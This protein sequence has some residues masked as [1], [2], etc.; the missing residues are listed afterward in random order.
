VL[1]GDRSETL[2]AGMAAVLVGVPIIH[3]HGG[4]ESQGATDNLWR[5]ALTKLSHLHLVSHPEHAARVL[6]MGEDPATVFVVGA[7]GLDNLYRKDLPSRKSIAREIGHGLA[8]PLVIVTVHPAMAGSDPLAEVA[9]VATALE[10]VEATYLITQPNADEGGKA[11]R[12][13]WMDWARGR[14]NVALVDALGDARYWALLREASAVLGNSSS[15][16]IEAPSIGVPVVNVGDRQKGRMRYGD[17]A[18]VP[19][20]ADRIAAALRD[21]LRAGR[22]ESPDSRYMKGAA[23]PR[24]VEVLRGWRPQKSLNKFFFPHSP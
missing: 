22:R 23:A 4:E 18:D 8:D 21:A 7:P 16:I 15:G 10:K 1:I 24:I 11:I 19:V 2:A 20:D 13:F 5:H 17:V 14:G 6:Q 12:S 3:L 9:A